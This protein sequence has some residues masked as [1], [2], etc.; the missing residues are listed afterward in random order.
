[1]TRP[2]YEACGHP[3]NRY[4]RSEEETF[5]C[6]DLRRIQEWVAAYLSVPGRK[7]TVY[8]HERPWNWRMQRY[9]GPLHR[10]KAWSGVSGQSWP[11]RRP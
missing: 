2:L 3:V 5:K 1:M 8:R 10:R 7:V 11:E 4:D 6:G 9:V